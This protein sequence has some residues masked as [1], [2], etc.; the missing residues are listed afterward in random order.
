LFSLRVFELCGAASRSRGDPDVRFLRRFTMIARPIGDQ[1][2]GSFNCTS[3]DLEREQLA[4]L[5]C[6][7]RGPGNGRAPS[8]GSCSASEREEAPRRVILSIRCIVHVS[9]EPRFV[10]FVSGR[11]ACCK[12]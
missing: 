4:Y 12:R 11:R 10:S 7:R 1:D 6:G 5:I 3:Y 2:P 8:V 9:P